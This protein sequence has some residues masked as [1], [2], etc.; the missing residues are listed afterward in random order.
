[1]KITIICIISI[2]FILLSQQ[3]GG[4]DAIIGIWE[5]FEDEY[6]D[7]LEIFTQDNKYIGKLLGSGDPF[8]EHGNQRRDRNNP[9]VNLRNRPLMGIICLT[10]LI[11]VEDSVWDGGKMYY[12]K[13]GN[14]YSCKISL[15]NKNTI[16][17]RYYLGFSI[18][19]YSEKWNRIK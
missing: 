19:G 1:M 14:I 2:P 10:D 17:A 4:S 13:D 11:Y 5:M 16:K 8:D 3:N 15:K 6:I 7:T 9:D 18:L 12:P